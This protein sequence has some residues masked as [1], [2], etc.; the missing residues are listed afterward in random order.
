MRFAPDGRRLRGCYDLPVHRLALPLP[1][2]ACVV[3]LGLSLLACSAEVPNLHNPGRT[4]VCLGDS[5]TAGVGAGTGES[6]PDLLAARFG[7]EVVN[8]GV[9]GETAEQG[10]ERIEMALAEAPWLVVVQLGGNDLLR[11]IPPA[12]TEAA[13]ESIVKRVLEHGAVPLLVELDAPFGEAYRAIFDR[14]G[15]RHPGVPVV[16][17]ALG[18]VLR[19]PGR[20]A[21]AV[22]PN[23]AG[24]R[25]LAEAIGDE[26]EPLLD[27]RGGS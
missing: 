2:V 10:L 6:Y 9:P 14:L 18:E 22:H 13:L 11:G 1:I 12:K 15:E 19:S 24:Y 23:A 16:R 7:V 26:I 21:D 5:I 3:G 25:D 8:A 27:A 4:I 20:K 17:D